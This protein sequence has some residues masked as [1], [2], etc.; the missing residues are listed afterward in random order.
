MFA[1]ATMYPHPTIK[2]EN[3]TSSEK[4]GKE[5]TMKDFNRVLRA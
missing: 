2:G 4:E 3:K 5:V 1:N